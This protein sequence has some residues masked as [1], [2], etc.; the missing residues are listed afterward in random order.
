MLR[1]YFVETF[2]TLVYQAIV[3]QR[4]SGSRPTSAASERR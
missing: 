2:T 3:N 4:L 1:A